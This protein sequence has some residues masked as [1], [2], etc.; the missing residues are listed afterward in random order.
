MT[1]SPLLREMKFA[2]YPE[3]INLIEALV[4][5][6]RSELN[7]ND[8]LEANILVS[9]SEAFNNAIIH[10]NKSNPNKIVKL[11][12]E[13]SD[14]EIGF[15]IEDEGK[16]FNEGSIRDPTSLEN[17]DKPTG[18]GIFLMKNLADRIEFLEGG[19][20]ISISFFLN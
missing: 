6:L 11:K 19:R 8:E 16:G 18:R 9:L 12:I 14:N 17:L 3:N 5:N 2:S 13:V 10:G 20:I 1:K 15:F 4:E 7:L